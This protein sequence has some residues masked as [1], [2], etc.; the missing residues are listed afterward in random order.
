[1]ILPDA[2]AGAAKNQTSD[3]P[4][5]NRRSR[6]SKF[7]FFERCISKLETQEQSKLGIDTVLSL[8]TG[9]EAVMLS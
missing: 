3:L 2:G 1:L 4:I 8:A 5:C 6:Q 7:L 9:F